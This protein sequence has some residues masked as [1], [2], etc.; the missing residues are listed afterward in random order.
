M[1]EGGVSVEDGAEEGSTDDERVSEVGNADE[2]SSYDVTEEAIPD[3]GTTVSASEE[4]AASEAIDDLHDVSNVS[5]PH[6]MTRCNSRCRGRQG[7][8]GWE[9]RRWER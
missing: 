3:E 5:A 1:E 4:E 8:G 7:G 2:E 6:W 9:V